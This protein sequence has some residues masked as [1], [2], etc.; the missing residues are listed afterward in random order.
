MVKV[1]NWR[2]AE[3]DLQRHEHDAPRRT[4]PA[5]VGPP[6]PGRLDKIF[7]EGRRRFPEMNA[8]E[9]HQKPQFV[10]DQR[11]RGYN[12]DIPATRWAR[13][14]EL[15][16]SGRPHFDR[17]KFDIQNQPD[18][19]APGGSPCTASGQDVTSSPFSAAHHAV[20]DENG[21]SE[22]QSFKPRGGR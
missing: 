12:P 20:R 15:G 1:P 8:T 17:G 22:H 5:D 2:A 4:K 21:W 3:K 18:R 11:A 19:R 16:G 14:G 9:E 10:E 6:S 7:N 13:G